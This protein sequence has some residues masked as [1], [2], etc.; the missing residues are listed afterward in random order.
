MNKWFLT[1]MMLLLPWLVLG[2]G[3]AQEQ[4]DATVADLDKTQQELQSV[5]AELDSTKAELTKVGAN[6]EKTKAELDK[7]KT[8]L[9]TAVTALDKT[10]KELPTAN[11]DLEKTEAELA[12]VRAELEKARER[13][14]AVSSAWSSLKPKVEV[15]SIILEG[16]ETTAIKNLT[17]VAAAYITVQEYQKRT[18]DQRK[19]IAVALEA[20]G[21]DE[22]TETIFGKESIGIDEPPEHIK[23]AWDTGAFGFSHTVSERHW[24]LWRKTA[25]ILIDLT[26]SDMQSLSEQVSP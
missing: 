23:G 26:N 21:N 22:L 14:D 24:E 11:S 4:Y 10:K 3:I 18:T 12:T 2:C 8:A 13:I 16:M 17:Y 20:I 15:L 9:T 5:R 25:K 19:R 1:G 6:L 7:T